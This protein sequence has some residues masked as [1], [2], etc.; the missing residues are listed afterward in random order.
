M[1]SP[2]AVELQ[3]QI[4]RIHANGRAQP[5]IETERHTEFATSW[6]HQ[7]VALTKRN[8]QA[9]WRNPTYLIAKIILNI[10]CGLLVGFTF[11]QAKDTLQGMQNKLFV[12]I[13]V[14]RSRSH[15][16]IS[17]Q[18][19][20]ISTIV[21]VPLSQQLQSIYISIRS[22][23]EVRERPSRMYSWTALVTSQILVEIPWNIFGSSLFF[24][25]WYWTVDYS[26]DRAG[27]TYL[28][29]GIAFPLY[30]TTIAQAIASMTPNAEVASIVFGA[31]FSF[32][33]LVQV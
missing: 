4:E 26:I 22:I 33:I 16:F 8:F 23:Y 3:E 5:A 28:M 31:L 30:Y 32:I 6:I 27:Y 9:Y 15:V 12:R 24:L 29:Y 11:F 7:A 18:A 25:C 14:A 20:F 21:C 10:A 17:L 13:V 19:V 1:K 2:E